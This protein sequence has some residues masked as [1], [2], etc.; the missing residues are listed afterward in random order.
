MLMAK[1]APKWSLP[2]GR[3]QARWSAS[4]ELRSGLHGARQPLAAVPSRW[5]PGLARWQRLTSA[6]VSSHFQGLVA[7]RLRQAKKKQG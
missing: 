3:R 5:F 1:P 4:D 7:S 6:Q 2:A